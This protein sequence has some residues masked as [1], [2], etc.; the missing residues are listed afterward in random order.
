MRFTIRLMPI[1][2]YE[3]TKVEAYFS[4]MASKGFFVKKIR[5]NLVTFEKGSSEK[6]QYRL[7]PVKNEYEEPEQEMLLYYEEQGWKYICKTGFFYLYQS[8]RDNAT[9]IHTD[10]F[11][12]GET[13]AHLN[14][15]LQFN[16]GISIV[17][18]LIFGGFLLYSSFHY[19]LVYFN[20]KYISSVSNLILFPLYFFGIIKT[21][22]DYRKMKKLKEQLESGIKV[23]HNG[24]YSPSFCEY[25][26]LA[27]P[28]IFILFMVAIPRYS[29]NTYWEK[30]LS[31][32]AG[33][34]PT[35]SIKALE[36]SP[37][38]SV[39]DSSD[40]SVEYDSNLATKF[41]REDISYISYH[42]SELA[43]D[44]YYIGDQ[45]KIEGKESTDQTETYEPFL[46]TEY[47]RMRFQFLAKVLY[48]ELLD[49]K[50]H[51][52]HYEKIQYHEL[53]QVE[54]DEATLVLA[55]GSQMLFARIGEKVV[56]IQYHGQKDLE[57]A[58]DQIYK[59]I[60]DFE[61]A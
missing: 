51:R 4:H 27:I 52:N 47:Y 26:V 44:V 14:K 19:Y 8:T 11:I 54:F 13:F 53:T 29:S 55:D 46:E 48:K 59:A 40:F 61:K 38:F 9:E 49:N 2:I 42:W 18:Y 60:I 24:S 58:I 50:L 20:V 39:K 57:T 37:D 17:G 30:N 7:E 33:K 1:S 22:W 41:A 32:Y 6:T 25:F 45:G 31:A 15:K 23:I 36:T 28:W 10:P 12:Q 34:L 5:G 56:F 16:F 21:L 3:I 35:I 43:P